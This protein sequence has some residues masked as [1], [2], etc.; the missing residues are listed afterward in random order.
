MPSLDPHVHPYPNIRPS[1]VIFHDFYTK[2]S[3]I[4]W[5]VNW[6]DLL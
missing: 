5:R 1:M 4:V 2:T 6:S 3:I